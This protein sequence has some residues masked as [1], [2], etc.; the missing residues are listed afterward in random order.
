MPNKK[1]I[2]Q[3]LIGCAGLALVLKWSSGR[4]VHA[5]LRG[6]DANPAFGHASNGTV[7]EE[8]DAF[9]EKQMDRLNLPGAALAVVEGDQI[10]HMR[11]FGRAHPNGEMPSPQTPFCIGSTTKSFTALA[12]MQLVEGG[13]V[14]LDAPVQRYLPWFRV[15]PSQGDE[16][17]PQASDKISMR[18]LL[19]QTSGLPLLPG[20]QLLTDFDNRPDATERQARALST[21]KLT[22]PAGVTFEYSNLNYNLLGLIIEAASGESYAAYIQHHIFEPLGMHHSYTTKSAAQQDGLAV[23]HQSW[24][25]VPVAAPDLP[26]VSGSLPSGQLISS[27]EDMGRY[28]IAHLNGGRCGEAQILSPKGIAELHRPAVEAPLLDDAKGWYGMGW[29][30]E[31]QGQMRS[32]QH[33]GLVPDFYAFM[34][35]L[36][37]QKKGVILLVN[38]DH[39]TMQF[40]MSEV[41]AGL[42]RLLAGNLP[43]PTRFGAI[44]WIQRGLLLIP[45]LQIVDIA[46]TLGLI[47]RW[48]QDP[49]RHPGYGRML[50]QHILLPLVPNLLVTLTLI[51]ILSKLRG[52][53][54][55]FAPDFSWI[56]RI[57]GGFAGIWLFLRTGL[58]LKTL[59]KPLALTTLVGGSGN[60]QGNAF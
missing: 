38:I 9:I 40:T 13:K 59:R 36:P 57:S 48:R 47:H 8:I 28:L 26:M 32:L 30:I 37:E 19:N 29:Y 11:G 43:S 31:E 6:K 17:D 3:S 14:E 51:P 58:I 56:A 45:L 23:G 44:P 24:F 42:V 15:A 10:V 12:V 20:W 52:F 16:A 60:M 7:F 21:I 39:F 33:S 41:G 34:A 50:G 18:H 22:R 49:L 54:M 2:F 27:A 53:L 35:M 1:F 5:S 4:H 25:G 55:L 46:V